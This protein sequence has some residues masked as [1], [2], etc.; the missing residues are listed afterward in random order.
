M[1]SENFNNFGNLDSKETNIVMKLKKQL[2][3]E[4]YKNNKPIF[5]KREKSYLLSFLI[6][7]LFL[8]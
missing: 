4:F 2:I 7:F 3:N 8:Y 6:L 5:L 1:A